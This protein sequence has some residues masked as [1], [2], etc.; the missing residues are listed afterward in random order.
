MD[1]AVS[2]ALP[3]SSTTGMRLSV[4]LPRTAMLV[5]S[6]LQTDNQH[7]RPRERWEGEGKRKTQ[8]RLVLGGGGC[9][10]G[11]LF[12]FFLSASFSCSTTADCYHIDDGWLA[13][14]R[15]TLQ[16]LPTRL[17][18][19]PVAWSPLAAHRCPSV[20]ATSPYHPSP[21]PSSTSPPGAWKSL[22]SSFFFVFLFCIDLHLCFRQRLT[23]EECNQYSL[24]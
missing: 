17:A 19:F 2:L 4:L 15:R 5:S 13:G 10:A 23:L 1:A 12:L 9:G 18:V 11:F 21:I 22:Q 7:R 3:V 16:S 8:G 24:G 6:S 20:T 14:E